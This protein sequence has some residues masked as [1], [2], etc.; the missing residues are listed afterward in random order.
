MRCSVWQNNVLRI[1]SRSSLYKLIKRGDY[2]P[3]NEKLPT[4]SQTLPYVHVED[5]AFRL[6]THMM[7]PY[8]RGEARKDYEKNHF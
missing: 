5:E 6:E 7:R 2:F 4:S 3:S 8:T 1:F